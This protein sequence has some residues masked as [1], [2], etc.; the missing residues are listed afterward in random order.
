MAVEQE[1]LAPGLHVGREQRDA[2]LVLTLTLRGRGGLNVV[3]SAALLQAAETLRG[4][5]TEPD[6]RCAV[7]RGPDARA[8]VGGADLTELG[9]L[10]RDTAEAFIRGIH[11]VCAALRDFPVP[12]IA[13]IE[14]YCLGGGLEIAAAC[15]FRIAARGARLGMPEV[16]VGVPSVIEAALLP[17][18]IGWGRTREFLLRGHLVDAEEALRIGLVEHAVDEVDLDATLEAAID[19]IL[20]GAPAA[21]RAQKRLIRR[22]EECGIAGAIE[23]GVDAFV[24]AY[25]TVEPAEYA[26]RFF[27]A[28]AAHA[29]AGREER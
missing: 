12:V 22:W 9:S 27:A 6:L 2:G 13:A 7:L 1:T 21:V 24:A 10:T 19:D 20:A 26:A 28:R 23:A 14:G 4:L 29:K 25:G 18:L 15:D 3:G 8:F 11:G 5:A 17:G 16:R